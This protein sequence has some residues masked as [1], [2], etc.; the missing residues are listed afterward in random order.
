MAK[1]KP[2]DI[3]SSILQSTC[4]PGEDQEIRDAAED[5]MMS[6]SSFIRWAVLTQ[7][8]AGARPSLRSREKELAG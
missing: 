2:L 4:T 1:A 7:I 5:M 6:V 3:R 8:R